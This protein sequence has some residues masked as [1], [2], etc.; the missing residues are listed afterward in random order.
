MP[1]ATADSRI[2][3]IGDIHGRVDLLVHLQ[4]KILADA[5]RSTARRRVIV[6]LGDYVDRGPDSRAVVDRLLNHRL[7][8][9]ETVHLRGNHEDM[10]LRFLAGEPVARL[11]FM[12]GGMQTLRSYAVS[13]HVEDLPAA[14]RAQLARGMPEEH[15]RFLA[16]L[17][18]S[19]IE[20]DYLFVH[21]GIRPGIPLEAQDAADLLWIREE[22]L[23]SADPHG[24][25]VV[26]GHTIRPR[27]EVLSN[28]IG[29]DTGAFMTGRLTAL[30]LEGDEAS[31]LAT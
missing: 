6:Y 14:A 26:H 4:A 1:A 21:A 22:F 2:Y 23:D 13:G 11:W 20:G 16:E 25:V 8:G 28:R 3:A 18:L 27:P 15:R 24:K 31:F 7:D 17:A 5:T 19:H 30:V 10:L 9:F 29:I 12:N